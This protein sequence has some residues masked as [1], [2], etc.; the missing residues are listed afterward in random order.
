[1]AIPSRY[2]GIPYD[3]DG[4]ITSLAYTS[5]GKCLFVN[6]AN[7]TS[8][9]H[10]DTG[11]VH[12]VRTSHARGSDAPG[13]VFVRKMGTVKTGTADVGQS[14]VPVPCT[15]YVTMLGPSSA[16]DMKIAVHQVQPGRPVAFIRHEAYS[17]T[18]LCDNST[19]LLSISPDQRF[20][21]MAFNS[22]QRAISIMKLSSI[23]DEGFVLI[24][25]DVAGVRNAS[26]LSFSSDGELLAV[27]S[28][29]SKYV[30]VHS[31]ETLLEVGRFTFKG[32][33]YENQKFLSPNSLRAVF[34]PVQGSRLF[35]TWEG[36]TDILICEAPICEV[37]KIV[38]CGFKYVNCVAVSPDGTRLAIGVMDN[39][40][41]LNAYVVICHIASDAIMYRFNAGFKYRF[42]D[43]PELHVA[44]SHDG[45]HVAIGG[46]HG[47]VRE[48]TICDWSDR[49]HRHFKYRPFRR[50]VFLL[51][52]IKARLEKTGGCSV[53][54]PR[55]PMEMWL[56][57]F[58]ALEPLA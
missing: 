11:T 23:L 29:D 8:L 33:E 49:N 51:M 31:T 22:G 27:T 5:D 46:N 12:V 41:G 50:T 24:R 44:F 28:K 15:A 1:M 54:L 3:A 53:A 9:T 36:G 18:T 37:K 6:S 13:D 35:A 7:K 4:C 14:A 38:R 2:T 55:L 17:K 56:E 25:R 21:A 57:V 47:Y 34:S 40:V 30:S 39:E 45:K 10:I 32:T 43:I 16:S 20:V 52:C 58:R 48:F 42:I 26:G 19:D